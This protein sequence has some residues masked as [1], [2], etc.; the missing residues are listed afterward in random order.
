MPAV[1]TEN[2]FKLAVEAAADIRS[3]H[4]TWTER[5]DESGLI[6]RRDKSVKR[7]NFDER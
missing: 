2:P 4:E 1:A 3:N 5:Q 7:L 6:H